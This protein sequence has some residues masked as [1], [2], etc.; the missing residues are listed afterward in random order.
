MPGGQLPP[1][2][3][4]VRQESLQYRQPQVTDHL[5]IHIV[6]FRLLPSVHHV[7]EQ[8]HPLDFRLPRSNQRIVQHHHEAERALHHHPVS[9]YRGED[10][11]HPCQRAYH[12]AVVD[13]P[14][15]VKEDKVK[16][17]V[18]QLRSSRHRILRCA[19]DDRIRLLFQSLHLLVCHP[20]VVR[21]VHCH[22][23]ITFPHLHDAMLRIV[24]VHH[25]NIII[26]YIV[27]VT[28]HQYGQRCFTGSSLLGGESDVLRFLFHT[29]NF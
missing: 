21:V 9:R 3:L 15:Q 12:A 13:S 1:E 6:Q 5:L 19:L 10:V 25:G 22:F 16:V 26:H 2:P 8:V 27:Q 24:T 7:P 17:R 28:C 4:A 20:L 18:R 14:R 29:F 23:Q 11:V